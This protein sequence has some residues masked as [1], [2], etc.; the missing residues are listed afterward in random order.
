[1]LRQLPTRAERLRRES[2]LLSRPSPAA[3]AVGSAAVGHR[4]SAAVYRGV[5]D[6]QSTS[7]VD[8]GLPHMTANAITV[9]IL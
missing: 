7:R 6:D 4:Q 9:G 3:A 1:M 2:R 5:D 8:H